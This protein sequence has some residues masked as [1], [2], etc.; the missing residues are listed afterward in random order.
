MFLVKGAF[1]N[2]K[3]QSTGFSLISLPKEKHVHVI[4][5]EVVRDEGYAAV[6]TQNVISTSTQQNQQQQRII[7]TTEEQKIRTKKMENK[8]KSQNQQIKRVNEYTCYHQAQPQRNRYINTE[9]SVQILHSA[10][11]S[12]NNQIIQRSQNINDEVHYISEQDLINLHS[13]GRHKNKKY[14]AKTHI[15][16]SSQDG[17]HMHYCP[18]CKGQH[19]CQH[20]SRYVLN[21]RV[22]GGMGAH[23]HVCEGGVCSVCGRETRID[24]Q[25]IITRGAGKYRSNSVECS[26]CGGELRSQ[27][28]VQTFEGGYNEG[29]INEGIINDG[30]YTGGFRYKK[31]FREVSPA[32]QV[33]NTVT[34]T[35]TRTEVRKGGEGY[36][37]KPETQFK[38]SYIRKT[39]SGSRAGKK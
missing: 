34:E 38:S 14:V 31:I 10:N 25:E 11:Q 1:N 19:E 9:E 21:E 8:N 37:L 29:N 23:A 22:S 17:H 13:S 5:D 32:Q 30:R 35:T 26:R 6:Q 24:G 36:I 16:S 20:I 4:I 2:L 33:R 18:V 39:V 27:R 3:I 28:V 7:T 15:A 12:Q